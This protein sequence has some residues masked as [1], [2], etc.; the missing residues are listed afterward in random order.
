ML[1]DV[2]VVGAVLLVFAG[3]SGRL[4]GTPLTAP[5]AFVALGLLLGDV[6]LGV[7]RSDASLETVRVLSEVTLALV[8]F[9]DA[10]AI[11]TRALRREAGPPVRLLGLALPMTIVL[12]AL[13]AWWVVPG[14]EASTA[15]LLAVLLAPTDA[16]LGQVVV[17]DRR[18][19]LAAAAGAQRGERAQRRHLRA[20]AVRCARPRRAAGGAVAGL[21]GARSTW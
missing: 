21:G 15:V 6:G 16:A 1:V 8:L 20:A 9:A 11:R 4:A 18:L 14:L 2:V 17:A 5:I 7:L 19:P 3:V 13:L 12:G 10:S